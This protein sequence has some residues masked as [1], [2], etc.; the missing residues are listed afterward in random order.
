VVVPAAIRELVSAGV[1]MRGNLVVLVLVLVVGRCR[2]VVA[3]LGQL[4]FGLDPRP[5]AR[6]LHSDRKRS[7]HRE[8]HYK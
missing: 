8:K 1:V 5:R 3:V 6:A 7:P 4:S 2:V